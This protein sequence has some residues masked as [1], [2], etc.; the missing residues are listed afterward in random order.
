MKTVFKFLFWIIFHLSLIYSI[1][2]TFE[3]WLESIVIF[4]LFYFVIYLSRLILENKRRTAA[5][6]KMINK[7][8]A[9]TFAHGVSIDRLSEL[10]GENDG[11]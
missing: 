4:I 1:F 5:Q 2:H 8:N 9:R 11:K 7:L 6:D 10:I 3:P